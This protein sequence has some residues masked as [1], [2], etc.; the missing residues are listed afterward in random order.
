VVTSF[1]E[2]KFPPAMLGREIYSK[3]KVPDSSA[4]VRFDLTITG[5]VAVNF[6]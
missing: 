3:V 6:Q 1:S 4:C 5:T 2:Q